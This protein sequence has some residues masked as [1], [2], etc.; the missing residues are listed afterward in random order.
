M[1]LI[2]FRKHGVNGGEVTIVAERITHWEHVSSNGRS[3]TEVHLDS[4]TAITVDA[5]SSDVGK[6]VADATKE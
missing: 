2:T 1:K 3:V 4:G 6:K 5:L